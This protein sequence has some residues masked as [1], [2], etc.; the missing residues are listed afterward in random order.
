MKY[1]L[2]TNAWVRSALRKDSLPKAVLEVLSQP[3]ETFGLSAI[4]IWEVAKK[5]QVGKLTLPLATKAWF[6]KVITNNLV[7][8]PLGEEILVEATELRDFPVRD[9]ADEIIIAT[10]RHY[11]L[12]L[13]TSDKKLKGYKHASIHYYKPLT[14]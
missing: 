4:S 14:V 13:I 8:L 1:L 5:V 10:A 11:D 12:T 2:D 6:A 9:P 7:V 3:G